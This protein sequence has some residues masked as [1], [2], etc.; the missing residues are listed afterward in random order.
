LRVQ[1][2]Y[3]V[4]DHAARKEVIAM[5]VQPVTMTATRSRKKKQTP[6]QLYESLDEDVKAE[7]INGEVVTMSPASKEHNLLQTFF[8]RVLAEFAE[9]GKSGEVF[10]DQLEMRLGDQRY[11]PD[12]SFVAHEHLDRVKPTRIEGPADLVVEITSPDT[13]G[14]DWGVK[15]RDYEQAGI[16]EY[17]LVNPLVEQVQVYVL[18][19]EGKYIALAPDET[20]AYRSTV[21]PGLRILPRW[22]WPGADQKPDVRAAL[23][24]LGLR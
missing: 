22:L 12:V 5:A 7:L 19:S 2:A 8:V 4:T 23:H 9:Q 16:L 3:R 13:A 24:T 15:M 21:L 11:V 17:W 6:E 18:G 14:R 1:R 20:G 10:G